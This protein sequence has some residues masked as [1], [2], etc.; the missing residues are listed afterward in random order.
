MLHTG[1]QRYSF[2]CDIFHDGEYTMQPDNGELVDAYSVG[3]ADDAVYPSR[4]AQKP[5]TLALK[6]CLKPA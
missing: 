1:R 2:I 5:E 4:S 3:D 6:I